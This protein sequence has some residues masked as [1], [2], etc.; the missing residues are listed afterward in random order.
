MN[1]MKTIGYNESEL[2]DLIKQF[3]YDYKNE[4]SRAH[5]Q[6]T[7]ERCAFY[8]KGFLNYLDVLE[9]NQMHPLYIRKF[10]RVMS[11]LLFQS[12]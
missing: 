2:M 5:E 7:R 4:Y 10:Q 1:K 6:L 3:Y 12:F 9:M 8:E 11:T